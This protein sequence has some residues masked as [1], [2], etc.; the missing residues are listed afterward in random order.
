M[1]FAV[2]MLFFAIDFASHILT[3]ERF[4]AGSG[5]SFII[6]RGNPTGSMMYFSALMVV[7]FSEYDILRAYVSSYR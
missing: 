6:K 1:G 4:N 2:R 3:V 7:L 5:P